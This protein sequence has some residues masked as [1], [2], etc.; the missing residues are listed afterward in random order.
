M[1]YV[2]S[3]VGDRCDHRAPPRSLQS[4]I[5]VNGGPAGAIG[6][7]YRYQPWRLR[8]LRLVLRDVAGGPRYASPRDDE[9]HLN[10]ALDWLCVAQDVLDER[11]DAGG[12]SA[13]WSFDEGWLPGY[14]E[15]TG[16][17]VETFIEAAAIFGRS[18]L[19]RRAHRMIDWLLGLQ[20]ADGAFPGHYGEPGSKPVIFN[21]GQIMHGLL[22]GSLQLNRPECLPA[23]VRAGFWLVEQQDDDGCWRRS[24]HNDIPHTYDTRASWALLRAG[25]IAQEK[26]LA[27][28]A[29][30]QLDWA[31]TQ[32]AEDGWFAS[33]AFESDAPPFTH[34]IA[35]AIR[36]FLESS[37]LVSEDRYFIAARRAAEALARR[38]RRDGWLAGRYGRNWAPQ[39]SYCCLTGLA[40]MA[41]NWTKLGGSCGRE[42]FLH[43]ARLAVEYLKWH[44]NVAES[45][46]ALRGSVAGSYPIWGAYARF[47]YPAWA[48]KFF[49]DAIMCLGKT[50][51]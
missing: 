9:T 12:V 30:N 42:E 19:T 20:H 50:T 38:Q 32:Q 51:K 5:M 39:A 29:R 46:P 21:T 7:L 27:D 8:H 28:A 49:A 40:Q 22:A 4:E 1:G 41:V 10:A 31:L 24:Q 34:T 36:G 26:T 45:N 16:Y 48:A 37:L 11:S 6:R 33:N 43:N 23:A 13:G 2:Y 44:H 14:P 47:S 17:I 18:D 35:Y 15:T 25:L 3:S